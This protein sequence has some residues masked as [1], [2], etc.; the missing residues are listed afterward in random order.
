ML[1]AVPRDINKAGRLTTLKH[2]NSIPAVLF[3]KRVNGAFGPLGTPPPDEA[4]KLSSEDSDDHDWD[5]IGQARVLFTG[6]FAGSDVVDRDDSLAQL[7]TAEGLVELLDQP[8]PMPGEPN[9]TPLRAE[10]YDVVYVLIGQGVNLPYEIVDVVGNVN[11]P[12]YTRKYMFNA[13]DDLAYLEGEI[14]LPGG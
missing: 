8:K 3:R 2:P 12:P 14:D 13:R 7:P 6:G 1:N 5:V 9:R 4:G 10:K 11:I